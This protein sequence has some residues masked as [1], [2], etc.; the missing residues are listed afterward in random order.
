[1]VRS[2]RL[3]DHL[4]ARQLVSA[5]ARHRVSGC[6]R[7][8]RAAAAS[9]RRAC[10]DRGG[11]GRTRAL[12]SACDLVRARL[13]R[14]AAPIGR[15][16]ARGRPC[17]ARSGIFRRGRHG[18]A[19]PPHGAHCRRPGDHRAAYSSQ[20]GPHTADVMAAGSGGIGRI[21]CNAWSHQQGSGHLLDLHPA[22]HCPALW[23]PFRRA[24]RVLAQ[25]GSR[26][27]G[28]R[29]ARGLR[30]AAR[31]PGCF[32]G[33]AG[34]IAGRLGFFAALCVGHVR[35]LSDRVRGMDRRGHDRLCDHVAGL[36]RRNAGHAQH[37]V[38]R[39]CDRACWR[40]ISATIPKTS[41]RS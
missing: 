18:G 32:L 17:H 37:R 22:A 34:N 15:R 40:S 6:L 38:G 11:A 30:R 21:D 19:D 1:M 28:Q 5:L 33:P 16:L 12:P 23:L 35:H 13:R 36:G 29:A 2:S 26:D 7:A 31:H 39:R 3:S 14:D 9:R 27:P 25:V 20:R 4:A 8:L 10:L 41:S 24:E